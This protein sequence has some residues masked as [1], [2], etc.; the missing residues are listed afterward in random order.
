MVPQPQYYLLDYISLNK[1]SRRTDG[2]FLWR[3]C[4]L[5]NW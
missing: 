5:V 3:L 4:W 1:F 2:Y